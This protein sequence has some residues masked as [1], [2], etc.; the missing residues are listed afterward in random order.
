MSPLNKSSEELSTVSMEQTIIDQYN[1]RIA[2]LRQEI[3]MRHRIIHQTLMRQVFREL[4]HTIV[5]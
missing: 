4:I 2:Q 1:Q 3:E 5:N